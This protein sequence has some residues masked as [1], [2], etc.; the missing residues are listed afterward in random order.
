MAIE[1]K[2]DDYPILYNNKKTLKD[3]SVDT[4]GSSGHAYMTESKLL[5]IDFD[6][7]KRLYVNEMGHSEDD[8]C[9]L[10]ALYQNND[11]LIFFEF[12]NGRVNNSNVRWKAYD[13]LMILGGILNITINQLRKTA[14]LI[15]VYNEGVNPIGN[16]VIKNTDAA[17]SLISI[18]KRIKGLAGEE[19]I[20]FNLER[21]KDLYY[22]DVHTF[23]KS[24][25]EEYLDT[26]VG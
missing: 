26:L 1:C 4:S 19:L 9:S 15:I 17:P 18:S 2:L 22:K 10:D 14:I 13:S 6:E 8:A 16:S 11:Q 12:K 24:E 21:F 23:T 3:L 20:R 25:F 5:A 7:V